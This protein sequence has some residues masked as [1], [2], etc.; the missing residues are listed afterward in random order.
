MS[1]FS[2]INATIWAHDQDLTAQTNKVAL[3]AS[4][5][6]LDVTNFASGG[7]VQRI[8]GLKSAAADISG[9]W[10]STPDSAQ[11]AALGTSGRVVTIS[12][13]GAE[14]KTAYMFQGGQFS[15]DALGAVVGQPADFTAGFMN[16][17]SVAGMVRGQMAKAKGTVSAT[18]QLGSIL[19]MTGP[20]ASQFLYATLHVFVASTT[21]TVQIQSATT[22]GFAGPTLRGTIGPIT[23][24]GGTWLVRVP[25]AITDGFYRMNVSAITGTFTVGGAIAVGS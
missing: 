25:G 9:F 3:H 4:V 23:V 13:E 19:T 17:E 1:T 6:E 21:I 15:Y 5:D 22:L 16:T 20:T 7:Y 18:G 10:D 2:L 12:P 8:G 24:A 11:F 14:T